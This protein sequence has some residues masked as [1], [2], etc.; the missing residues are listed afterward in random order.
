MIKRRRLV[1]LSITTCLLFGMGVALAS[2]SSAADLQMVVANCGTTGTPTA[3]VSGYVG[4]RF[5]LANSVQGGAGACTITSSGP[6]GSGGLGGTLA[7][8]SS[9]YYNLNVA[10]SSQVIATG[11]NN[12]TLTINVTV[13]DPTAVPEEGPAPA[14]A[15]HLQQVPVPASGSC[16][17]VQDAALAWGTDV[18]GGWSKAWGEGW[19]DAWVC[20][21]VLT[22]AG[23]TWHATSA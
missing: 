19:A 1:A 16:A 7:A 14:P 5:V 9:A 13:L 11:T 4:D 8:G 3:S 23:G 18:T 6:N 21:R 17:D 22:N 2:P 15:W 20:S 12:Y 10:G